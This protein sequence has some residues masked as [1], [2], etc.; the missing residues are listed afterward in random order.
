MAKVKRSGAISRK[1]I[2]ALLGA[3]PAETV[4]GIRTK[5]PAK[6]PKGRPVSVNLAGQTFGSW[7]VVSRLPPIPGKPVMWTC[8]CLCGELG[9]VAGTNLVRKQST[10]CRTCAKAAARKRSLGD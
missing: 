10:R 3:L 8:L 4:A 1:R 9:K 6:K 7:T 2:D 5:L